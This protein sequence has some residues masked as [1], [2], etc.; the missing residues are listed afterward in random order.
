MLLPPWLWRVLRSRGFKRFLIW[1][2][3][4]MALAA[5]LGYVGVNLH[6]KKVWEDTVKE[7]NQRGFPSTMKEALG[8]P[9]EGVVDVSKVQVVLDEIERIEMGN[10]PLGDIGSMELPG[11]EKK[12]YLDYRSSRD[13]VDPTVFFKEPITRKEAAERILVLLEPYEDRRRSLLAVD[14]GWWPMIPESEGG[15]GLLSFLT[16]A[17]PFLSDHAML[18]CVV[19]RS[20]LYQEDLRALVNI[21]SGL[22]RTPQTLFGRVIEVSELGWVSCVIDEGLNHGMFDRTFLVSL[23]ENLGDLEPGKGMRS[24]FGIEASGRI[25]GRGLILDE[26]PTISWE[27]WFQDWEMDREVLKN[28]VVSLKYGFAPIGYYEKCFAEAVGAWAEEADKGSEMTLEDLRRYREYAAF[29]PPNLDLETSVIDP[30]FLEDARSYMELPA[31]K[32]MTAEARLAVTRGAIALE[33]ARIDG[34]T[35]PSSIGELDFV[36]DDPFSDASLRFR[37]ESDGGYTLWSVGPNEVDD[38]GAGDD[39][40]FRYWNRRGKEK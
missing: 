21:C 13:G 8:E 6:G 1:F 34:G 27:S 12:V 24:A 2:P 15:V 28:K 26:P 10:D 18:A 19:G 36:G 25:E 40:V 14:A 20:D 29:V 11:L 17:V 5:V 30:P 4:S 39:I 22:D 31:R 33:V 9:P 35:Y 38:A 7:M 3:I 32:A 16:Y 23:S 37:P